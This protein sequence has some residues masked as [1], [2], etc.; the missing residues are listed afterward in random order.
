MAYIY[1]FVTIYKFVKLMMLDTSL[2]SSTRLQESNFV[3]NLMNNLVQYVNY[4]SID[5]NLGRF[6][7]FQRA[8]IISNSIQSGTSLTLT[9]LSFKMVEN[10]YLSEN[11]FNFIA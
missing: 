11:E 1:L 9:E 3:H 5:L 2:V 7:I 6:S 4:T 10:T 8:L